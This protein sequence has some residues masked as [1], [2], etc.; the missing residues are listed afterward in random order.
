MTRGSLSRRRHAL[1]TSGLIL[2]LVASLLACKDKKDGSCSENSDCP[3]NSFCNN[4]TCQ[5][6][7]QAPQ[8]LPPNPGGNGVAPGVAT[9]PAAAAAPAPAPAG[10]T[11][12][13]GGL[14]VG[15]HGCT[16]L[17]GTGSYNRVCTVSTLADG[18]L[19]VKAPGTSL[20]PTIGFEF[21]GT[22]GPDSYAIQG[23][24]TAFDAC[25][26]NFSSTA[27]VE[28]LGGTPWFI[29]KFAPGGSGS[30]RCKIMIRK[31]KL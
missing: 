16:M 27:K 18:S 29:A 30:E 26:S 21:T 4:G 23:K 28:N 2:A 12:T 7:A 13:A 9:D 15:K 31:N 6:P 11:V 5:V 17:D 3:A 1:E 20:N 22:G 14:E 24:M 8:G 25:S 10:Q 19:S